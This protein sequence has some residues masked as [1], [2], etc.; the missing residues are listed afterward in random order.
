[1]ARVYNFGAGPATLPLEVLERAREEL[2]D[3]A[4]RGMSLLEMSHRSPEYTEVHERTRGLVRRL[5]G[6][7]D[8]F[9]VLLLGGGATLQFAMVPLNLLGPERG[10]DFTIT[11]AWSRKAHTDAARLG[12]VRVVYDGRDD[13]YHQL[14]DPAALDIDPSAAY[15]YLTSNETIGGLQWWQLPDSGAVP[16]VCDM[17]S[18]IMSRQLPA[19][20]FGLIFAGAQ[21]NLGP[22]GVTLVLIR[23]DVLER[24]RQDLPAYLSYRSHAAKGSLY[25]TPPVF[26]VYLMGLVLEWIER[27]GGVAAMER[28]AGLKSAILYGV[29]DTHPEFY[30][31]P[32]APPCRSRMNVVFRLPDEDLERRFMEQAQA[33]GLVGLKGHR[34]VGGLRASIYNAMPPEGVEELARFMEEFVRRQG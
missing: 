23:G 29:I 2:L 32:V 33:E 13:D 27:Q 20:R 6:L 28:L 18:D 16:I 31:C 12:R 8:D 15:L 3:Y 22:A 30:R 1:M 14:P 24:C 21:K 11:G 9:Q 7:G 19:E 4:G 5:L 26:A 10:C 17:S 34:S 25:N